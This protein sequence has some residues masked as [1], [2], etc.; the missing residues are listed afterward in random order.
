MPYLM[1]EGALGGKT[2][3]LYTRCEDELLAKAELVLLAEETAAEHPHARILGYID[4]DPS[5]TMTQ[6]KQG[7][8]GD[9]KRYRRLKAARDRIIVTGWRYPEAPKL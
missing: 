6:F 5:F 3:A 9:Y 8:R 7:Y 2:I 1:R 4:V